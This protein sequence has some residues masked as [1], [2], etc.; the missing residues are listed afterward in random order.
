MK[1]RITLLLAVL[2][3]IAALFG[4]TRAG[5]TNPDEEITLT[6]FSTAEHTATVTA[7][8]TETTSKKAAKTTA[9]KGKTTT[10]KKTTPAKRTTT[11]SAAKTTVKRK[12]K[13]AIFR[14]TC[15][16]GL[17]M[18]HRAQRLKT[19]EEVKLWKAK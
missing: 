5:G 7:T 4:C 1:R 18:A 15:Y 11:K 14:E 13:K 19:G 12:I 3:I 8:V 16:D 9:K 10:A 17:E 2:L 6:Q